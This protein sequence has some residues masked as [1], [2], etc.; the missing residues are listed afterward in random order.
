ML[1]GVTPILCTPFDDREAID[2]E[3]LAAQ[4]HRLFDAGLTAV[5]TGIGSEIARLTE[6][7]AVT[8]VEV[9]VTALPPGGHLMAGVK[10]ESTAAVAR[11]AVDMVTAGATLIMLRPP[12]GYPTAAVVDHFTTVSAAAQVPVVVQ[13]APSPVAAETPI[14]QLMAL[15]NDVPGIAALKIEGQSRV[16]KI[17][18]LASMLPEHVTLIGGS[19]GVSLLPELAAGSR[20]T[21]PGPAVAPALAML[22]R[23]FAEEPSRA[24]DGYQQLLPLLSIQGRGYDTFLRLQK[25]LLWRAGVFAGVGVRRPSSTPGPELVEEIVEAIDRLP[26]ALRELVLGA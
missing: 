15:V 10:G 20:G 8:I 12:V 3:S 2:V 11:Q 17:G 14:D 16:A 1:A 4:V 21:M 24:W 9:A 25:E 23:Q 13:D 19:G 22:C 26:P 18:R 6:S 5:G 7:E